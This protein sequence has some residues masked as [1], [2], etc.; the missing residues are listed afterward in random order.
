M[1]VV[2]ICYNEEE[3]LPGF[4]N[5]LLPWVDEIVL[6]DDGSTDRSEELAMAAGDKVTFLKSPRAE[7]EGFNH[8]R[9]KGIDAATSDWLLHMDIDERVTPEL[10]EEILAAM[11]D[12]NRDGYRFRR[13]EHFLNQPIARGGMQNWNAVHL[14]R[15]EKFRFDTKEGPVFHE[16]TILDAP[17]ER[18]GQLSNQMWHL[19]DRDYAHRL[20]KNILYSRR[21]ADRIIESGIRVRWYHML[22][23][24]LY[25]A[26]LSY[27]YRGGYRDGM[28]GFIWALYS[29]SSI[30]SWYIMAWESQNRSNRNQIE[31]RLTDM[32]ESPVTS[33]SIPEQ[34][35][36]RC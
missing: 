25:R 26:C 19:N 23:V 2:A 35:D 24:P 4:F 9:N 13:L 30:F 20:S 12:P 21:E 6:V 33:N 28:V 15:R 1:G 7:G 22:A 31:K 5:C 34:L 14:A 8:Q 18:I 36:G 3:N 16:R 27:F 17:E 10:A 32:W 29:F 11:L